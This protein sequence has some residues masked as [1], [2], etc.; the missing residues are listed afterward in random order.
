MISFSVIA[1][2]ASADGFIVTD[3]IWQQQLTGHLLQQSYGSLP[4]HAFWHTLMP[5]L[6]LTALG[7]STWLHCSLTTFQVDLF[8]LKQSA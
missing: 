2:L 3:H 7:V 5:T 6:Q 4:L 8:W 1:V